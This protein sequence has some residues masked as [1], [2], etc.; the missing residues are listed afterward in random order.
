MR[1]NK[2]SNK[3][4][5][6]H[7][8][9]RTATWGIFSMIIS[10]TSSVMSSIWSVFCWFSNHFRTF[11]S[12]S[13]FP[14]YNVGI[15]FSK[16]SRLGIFSIPYS[17][18]SSRLSIFTKITPIWSHSSSMFSSSLRIFCDFRS[19]LSSKDNLQFVK[20]CYSIYYTE[21]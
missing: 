2:S 13:R 6:N 19:L 17:F 9:K 21:N 7:W 11:S 18:A 12:S 5:I 16:Y 15:P 1:V 20:R 8:Q 10:S 3:K 4:E 14:S